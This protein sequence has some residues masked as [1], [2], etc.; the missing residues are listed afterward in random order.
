[1]IV[2]AVDVAPE[3]TTLNATRFLAPIAAFAL[4]FGVSGSAHAQTPTSTSIVAVVVVPAAPTDA[5][6]TIRPST[7]TSVPR[8]VI[9]CE[10][11]RNHGEYVSSRPKGERAKAAKSDCGKPHRPTTTLAPKT[12]LGGP[13]TMV[14]TTVT[15]KPQVSATS[16]TLKR[17][18]DD[19]DEDENEDARGD[20]GN[21]SGKGSKGRGNEKGKHRD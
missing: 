13:T 11:A 14:T 8:R 17:H 16:T 6:T 15:T 7:S 5:T 4:V 12:T 20:K 18:D 3:E 9:T 21:R 19:Q 2:L 10:N 1:M